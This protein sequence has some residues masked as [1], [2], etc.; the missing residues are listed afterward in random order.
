MRST[1]GADRVGTALDDI[2]S[3]SGAGGG[4]ALSRCAACSSRPS[5]LPRADQTCSLDRGRL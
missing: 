4:L 5:A 2:A 3:V 1:T